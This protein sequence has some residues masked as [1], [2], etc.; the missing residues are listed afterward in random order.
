MVNNRFL[1]TKLWNVHGRSVDSPISLS[2][3]R[4]TYETLFHIFA[5]QNHFYQSVFISILSS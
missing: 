2:F 5:K 4:F 1:G 3:N